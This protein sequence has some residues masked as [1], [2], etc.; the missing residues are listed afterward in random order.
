MIDFSEDLISALR[1]AKTTT[2]GPITFFQLIKRFKN[3]NF[4]EKKE[5]LPVIS[6]GL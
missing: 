1:L 3:A 2:I 4:N 5:K 6:F